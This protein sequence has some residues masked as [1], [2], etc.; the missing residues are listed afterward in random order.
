MVVQPASERRKKMLLADMDSTMIQQECIDE[1]ADEVGVGDRVKEITARAMNG[2]LDFE[3]ALDERV[4]LLA[5][6]PASIID[7]F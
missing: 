4:A 7:K 6:Q 3:A 5:E 1:L 2:E